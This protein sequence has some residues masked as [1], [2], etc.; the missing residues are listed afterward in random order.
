MG[1]LDGKVA[2]VTG[3]SG[4]IGQAVCKTF[5][6]E[7]AAV[8]AT[9]IV[10]QPCQKVV[11]E[12]EQSGGKAI[13]LQTDVTSKTEVAHM[14]DTVMQKWG[15]IDILINNAGT[16]SFGSIAD[17]AEEEWDRV[18]RINL[19]SVFLCSQAVMGHMK[20]QKS[21][22]IVNMGSLAGKVGGIVVG[23]NY[24]A[25]K[26]GVLCITLSLAKELGPYNINVNALAP[27]PTDTDMTRSFPPGVLDQT[28]NQTPLKRQATPQDIANVILFL[29]TED[30]RHITGEVIDVNG[31]I[32]MDI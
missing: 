20:K 5:A 11:E 18:I 6:R 28:I 32:M 22:K 1:R 13:A 14:V 10:L 31:G 16:I 24:S 29:V 7:G 17:M 3:A 23:A 15:H 21:G 30:S 25:S 8:V 26:A 9:D 4:G 2:M 19:K 12:I 27:G